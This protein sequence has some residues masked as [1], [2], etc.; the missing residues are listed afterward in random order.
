MFCTQL[1]LFSLIEG[2]AVLK[3]NLVHL[4]CLVLAEL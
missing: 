4:N 1:I 3:Q 2:D